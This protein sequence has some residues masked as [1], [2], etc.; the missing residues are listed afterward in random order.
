MKK[1]L[2]PLIGVLLLVVAL[3]GCS[4]KEVQPVAIDEKKDKCDICQMAVKD[5]QYATQTHLENGKVLKFDD[6]GCMHQWIKENKNEKDPIH[7]VRDYNS[8]K[9]IALDQAVYVYD[10]DLKTPM[11]YGVVSFEK[12]SDAK[13]FIEKEGKGKLLKAEDLKSH[14]WER[15]KEMMEMMKKEHGGHGQ[16]DAG[17]SH[18][19]GGNNHGTDGNNQDHGSMHK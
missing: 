14:G 17:A 7:F 15:N 12:E 10:K 16:D 3:T 1:F 8:K 18:D 19:A 13:Q 4:E 2:L 6:I 9:W 5:D 11:A